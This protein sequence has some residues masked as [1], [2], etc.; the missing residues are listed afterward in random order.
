[1]AGGEEGNERAI[2]TDRRREKKIY[3]QDRDG[4]KSGQFAARQG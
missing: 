3:Q 4:R 2:R 1:M